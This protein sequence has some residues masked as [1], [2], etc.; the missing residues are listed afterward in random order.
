ML[1][2]IG[3]Q[4]VSYESGTATLRCVPC[5]TTFSRP[6]ILARHIRSYHKEGAQSE[7]TAT[8]SSL[9]AA[10]TAAAADVAVPAPIPVT[11]ATLP[12]T[13]RKR[14]ARQ[15][16]STSDPKD[17]EP[18]VESS[19]PDPK[20]V[21]PPVPST[22]NP[23]SELGTTEWQLP[24]LSAL[25]TQP[26]LAAEIADGAALE[27]FLN[28]DEP[29]VALPAA[30]RPVTAETRSDALPDIFLP[31]DFPALDTVLSPTPAKKARSVTSALSPACGSSPSSQT[32]QS[33]GPSQCNHS[34]PLDVLAS[35]GLA[36]VPD[37]AGQVSPP[38]PALPDASLGLDLLD[39]LHTLPSATPPI[40]ADEIMCNRALRPRYYAMQLYDDKA[41]DDWAE[42]E[43]EDDGV[44]SWLQGATVRPIRSKEPDMY[45][46]LD[47]LFGVE[48]NTSSRFW[49]ANQRFCIAYLYPWELPP[50]SRLSKFAFQ[51]SKT[52][53][54]VLPLAH[55]PSIVLNT[56]EPTF[57]FALSVAGAGL[58]ETHS[59][60]F[61]E[62]SRIKREFAA[63]HL[64]TAKLGQDELLASVQTLLLYQL[65]GAF[66][67]STEEQEYTRKHHAL[68]VQKFLELEIPPYEVPA[69]LDLP[70]RD[71]RRLWQ[72]WVVHETY[73]RVA[74]LC[75][76]LDIRH[77]ETGGQERLL[78]HNHPALAELPLPS[79]DTLWNAET[80]VS[81]REAV[82]QRRRHNA[83]F[84]PR[85][86]GQATRLLAAT[87][88]VNQPT[89]STVLNALLSRKPPAQGSTAARALAA[90]SPTS[91]LAV[92]V[93]LQTLLSIASQLSAAENLLR[94]LAGGLSGPITSL[95]GPAIVA[96]AAAST[97]DSQERVHFGLRVVR[98]LGGAVA[99]DRWFNGMEAIFR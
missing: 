55:G 69:N 11:T 1:A 58:F 97:R 41:K 99:Q 24:L 59:S 45:P 78:P 87:T 84:A 54:P 5:D 32:S 65:L 44:A 57:A 42:A 43:Y 6:D 39:E 16:E 61:D 34:S 67:K 25:E 22:R 86:S 15:D 17:A 26:N 73:V 50:L 70:E 56:V 53:L 7:N 29:T 21:E 68:L 14:I 76:L 79:S 33:S 13:R 91:P 9:P 48:R 4:S 75:Y 8:E 90:L 18:S 94:S 30:D 85:M 63:E 35:A 77:G 47:H 3:G 37:C 82:E 88:E 89:F 52:L 71:L 51:A 2:G 95:P 72:S 27:A 31:W 28:A 66:S 23:P 36:F 40:R 96:T 93:V 46:G 12:P 38:P 64:G 74:F 10:T 60:F 98:V 19:V 80:P 83:S 20:S 92:A 49:M 81:W 62:M